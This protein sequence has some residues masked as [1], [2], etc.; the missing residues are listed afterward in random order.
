MI[1]ILKIIGGVLAIAGVIIAYGNL[2]EWFIDKN[3]QEI[4]KQLLSVSSNHRV[5]LETPGV[6][7]FLE[8]YYYSKNIP[9]DMQSKPIRGLVGIGMMRFGRTGNVQMGDVHVLFENGKR[10][11]PVCTLDELRRWSSETPL[12]DWLGW[13]LLAIGVFLVVSIDIAGYFMLTGR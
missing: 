8:K 7:I 3:R 6:N 4:Y 5:S 9:S 12:Y 13:W 2:K 10:S 11:T 1:K